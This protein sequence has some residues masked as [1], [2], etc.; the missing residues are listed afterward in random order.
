MS[1]NNLKWATVAA[2]AAWQGKATKD[3]DLWDESLDY[4]L[5][6]QAGLAEESGLVWGKRRICGRGARWYQL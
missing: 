4:L 1:N 5:F 2:A 3:T 6:K